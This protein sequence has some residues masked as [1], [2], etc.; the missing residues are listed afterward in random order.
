M[1]TIGGICLIAFTLY[2]GYMAKLPIMPWRLF[3]R[4][5]SAIILVQGLLHDFVWQA[6][7]YFIP[8]YLQTV[9][10]YT[11]LQSATLILPFLLAQTIAGA[12]T[13]PVMFKTARYNPVLRTGF[14]AWTLGAA[15]KLIFSRNTPIAAYVCILAIEG[16]GSGWVHQPGLVA[17][18]ALSTPEDRAVATSTRNLLRSLGGVAGVAVSTAVQ[19]SV[20]EKALRKRVSAEIAGEVLAGRWAVG[21]GFKAHVMDAR[22]QGFQAVFAVSVPLI[23]ICLVGS[24]FVDDEVLRGDREEER[25]CLTEDRGG[26]VEEKPVLLGRFS[27]EG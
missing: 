21:D 14:I 27:W 12:S 16:L 25:G 17:L 10:G 20:T 9:R 5:S 2:E 6:T 19:F 18:Q 23:A 22:M 15:L 24:A 8:L 3:K 26:R 7:Q 11:P 4:R 1:I 13:G